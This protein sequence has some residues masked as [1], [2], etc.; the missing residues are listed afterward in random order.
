MIGYYSEKP[1]TQIIPDGFDQIF[2]SVVADLA[3]DGNKGNFVIST[4]DARSQQF[5]ERFVSIAN[6]YVPALKVVSLLAVIDGQLIE[7]LASSDHAAFWENGYQAL[8]IGD[9]AN[10]RNL[11]MHS[12]DDTI[13]LINYE[14][15]SKIVK[16]TIANIAEFASVR[17]CTV[18]SCKLEVVS[19]GK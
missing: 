6:K 10:T 4:S 19:V 14:F 8:H 5:G 15:A 11:Y 17:H 13:S 2:P 18:E 7:A 3:K 16:A 1:N 9:G 12:K